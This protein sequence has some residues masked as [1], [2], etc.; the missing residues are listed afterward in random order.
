MKFLASLL[1]AAS[2]TLFSPAAKAA[3]PI[4]ELAPL[5]PFIGTWR[6][7]SGAVDGTDTFTDISKWEW[8]LAGRVVRIT[9][10]V[11]DG[12]YAGE[13]L[14]HWDGQQG[15]IIYRYVNTADFFTDGVIT[16]TDGGINVHEYVR[17]ASSGP[18]ETRSFYGIKDGQIHAW[19][20]F[21]TDGEWSEK[22]D[23]VY[24]RA[25][26]AQVNLP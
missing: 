23:V 12:D 5:T 4:D 8:I 21:L 15:K 7:V 3:E 26:M 19:S 11:N 13:S 14:I 18:T 20:Q 2:F 22:S 6:S 10:N 17:G 1:L 24:E 25:P 16:P 9:H